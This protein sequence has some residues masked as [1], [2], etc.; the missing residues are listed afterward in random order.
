[1]SDKFKKDKRMGMYCAWKRRYINGILFGKVKRK[2]KRF[3]ELDW[4]GTIE[5]NKCSRNSSLM[6]R[7]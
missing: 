3:G 4:Y 1:M 2:K 7:V 5:L 6:W